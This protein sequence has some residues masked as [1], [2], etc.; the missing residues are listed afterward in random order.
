MKAVNVEFPVLLDPEGDF[1]K[2][3]SA[4]SCPSTFIITKGNITYGVNAALEWDD[5][6]II[7]KI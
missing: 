5:P 2:K 6:V 4:I 1:A 7:Q 3:W